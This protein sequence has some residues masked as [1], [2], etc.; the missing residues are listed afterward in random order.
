MTVPAYIWALFFG[1]ILTVSACSQDDCQGS[2]MD[3]DEY[4]TAKI[5]SLGGDTSML[6]RLIYIID[7]PGGTERPT[8]TSQ[9]EVTYT[10]KTTEGDEFDSTGDV[11]VT[12][13]LDQLIQAWQIG[14]PLIGR[15]GRIRMFVEPRL[16]YGAN[17]A[18]NLCPNTALIFDVQLIDFE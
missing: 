5:D 15:G 4:V 1:A 6:N 11:P 3:I 9:V 2:D 10:G 17:E 12:F 7:E 13:P 8:A 18:A 16:A 14:L